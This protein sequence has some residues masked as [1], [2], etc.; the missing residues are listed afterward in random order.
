MI[1]LF[2]VFPFQQIRDSAPDKTPAS[3]SRVLDPVAAV[4]AGLSSLAGF[5]ELFPQ[6]FHAVI[7]T[8]TEELLGGG[9]A[10]LL[11]ILFYRFLF[12]DFCDIFTSRQ[13]RAAKAA[14]FLSLLHGS[15]LL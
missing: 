13:K 15:D 6:A 8:S 4:I 7:Q 10:F 5:P 2:A 9:M 12:L 3:D 11:R 14:L 1:R